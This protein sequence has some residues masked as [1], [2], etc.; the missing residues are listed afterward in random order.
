MLAQY[1]WESNYDKNDRC[2][3]DM[4]KKEEIN[5]L[6]ETSVLQVGFAFASLFITN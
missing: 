6:K 3:V 2:F 1:L 5:Q 4:W